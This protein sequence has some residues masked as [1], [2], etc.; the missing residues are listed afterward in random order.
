MDNQPAIRLPKWGKAMGVISA[1]IL[2]A[3]S[4]WLM[5]T[6][7]LNIRYTADHEG[8]IPL[9]Y[10]WVPAIIC[11]LLIR[12]MPVHW[13]ENNPF[14]HWTQQKLLV[15]SG[16]LFLSA[17]LYTV[18]LLLIG[19]QGMDF[20][21][22]HMVFKLIFLLFIP[23]IFLL[24][25]RKISG[26]SRGLST[27]K[28]F[29]RR[30]WVAPLIIIVVWGCLK[31]FSP[32]AQPEGTIELADPIVLI[33]M[34][35]ISFLINSVLEEIFYRVWLQTRLE[36]LLGRWPAI[37]LVSILWAIWHI[38]IQGSGQ[39]DV[40]AATVIANHGLTGLFLGYLWARYRRVW[41]LI[42]IHGLI[43]ASPHFLMQILLP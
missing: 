29:S 32:L 35:V 13:Q 22:Y 10:N 27:A 40:D 41:P 19:G 39:W 23:L 38:S 15:Q 21:M 14:I 9:Y 37:L 4:L 8:T 28:S 34:V 17:V 16:V 43:N 3:A 18:S 25:H 7:N 12:L 33:I 2:V 31:F 6:G 26:Y 11:I 24:L 1:T 20:Q 5:W 36:V 30:S 42:V